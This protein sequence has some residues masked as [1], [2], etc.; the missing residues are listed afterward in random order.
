MHNKHLSS[1]RSLNEWK[2]CCWH[3][4][5]GSCGCNIEALYDFYFPSNCSSVQNPLSFRKLFPQLFK[6]TSKIYD[7]IINQSLWDT[8]HSLVFLPF[9][10]KGYKIP[11]KKKFF[12]LRNIPLILSCH[13]PKSSVKYLWDQDYFAPKDWECLS[14]PHRHSNSN[15]S[16]L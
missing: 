2:S 6:N 4:T 11:F 14:Q 8:C 5:K 1:P 3:K 9:I 12:D 13:T 16:F 7:I 10:K 15:P